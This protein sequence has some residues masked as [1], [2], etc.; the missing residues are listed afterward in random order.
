MSVDANDKFEFQSL[1][2]SSRPSIGTQK[3]Q[4]TER[5]KDLKEIVSH[6]PKY[7]HFNEFDKSQKKQR[8]GR[9]YSP[10]KP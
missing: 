4:L 6:L 7:N 1:G 10:S 3:A 8:G 5:V 9:F 2:V